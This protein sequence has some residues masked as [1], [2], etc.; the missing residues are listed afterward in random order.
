MDC[1][2]V[3]LYLDQTIDL[4]EKKNALSYK[5]TSKFNSYKKQINDLYS[6]AL[7]HLE[8]CLRIDGKNKSIVSVLKE[9][10]YKLGDSK[11]SIEMKKLEDSL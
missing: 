1:A 11:K 7:P 8:A 5:E 10:Y 6:L 9:I 2:T 4:I 3:S